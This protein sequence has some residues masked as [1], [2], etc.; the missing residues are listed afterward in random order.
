MTPLDKHG[1][2]SRT[3]IRQALQQGTASEGTEGQSFLRSSKRQDLEN[4]EVSSFLK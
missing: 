1:E 2:S 4:E 3:Q